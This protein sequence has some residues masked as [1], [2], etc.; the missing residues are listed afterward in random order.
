MNMLPV[1]KMGPGNQASSYAN[2]DM[3]KSMVMEQMANTDD[4]K[5]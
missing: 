1:D 2:S 5:S 3:V 4:N